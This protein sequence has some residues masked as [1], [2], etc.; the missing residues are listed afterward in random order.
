M[1]NGFSRRMVWG[2]GLDGADATVSTVVFVGKDSDVTRV[3]GL[4]VGR[5][6]GS[7]RCVSETRRVGDVRGFDWLMELGEGFAGRT[8]LRFRR[9]GR[10]RILIAAAPTRKGKEILDSADGLAAACTILSPIS[11]VRG[12]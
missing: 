7:P 12:G 3:N 4:R 8:K 9:A 6:A 2:G 5:G 10:S 1:G 11:L